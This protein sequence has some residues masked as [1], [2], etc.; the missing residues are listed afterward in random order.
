MQ[1]NRDRT[2]DQSLPKDD[3]AALQQKQETMKVSRTEEVATQDWPSGYVESELDINLEKRKREV[4]RKL[5]GKGKMEEQPASQM[6]ENQVAMYLT[7]F[8][9]L[10]VIISN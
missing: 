5:K 6:Q 3:T 9:V 7:C 1:Q 10:I 8:A 4:E 2:A